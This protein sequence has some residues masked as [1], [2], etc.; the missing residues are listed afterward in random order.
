MTGDIKTRE[1]I[2]FGKLRNWR[3]LAAVITRP[4][5][6]TATWENMT[7]ATE[8]VLQFEPL[9]T[10]G[11]HGMLQTRST[12]PAISFET[13]QITLPQGTKLSGCYDNG[14]LIQVVAPGYRDDAGTKQTATDKCAGRVLIG[15]LTIVEYKATVLIAH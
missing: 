6:R 13:P 4:E 3:D 1:S 14:R 5:S 10:L 7:L 2:S 8:L 11:G 12:V 9:R 15:Q